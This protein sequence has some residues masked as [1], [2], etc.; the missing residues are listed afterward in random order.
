[1]TSFGARLNWNFDEGVY[2]RA[3]VLDG[4]PGDPSHP[5]RTTIDFDANDGVL[6]LA[7]VGLTNDKGRLW[8]LGGWMYTADFPDLV[9]AATHD[10]NLGAYVALEERLL[11]RDEG[12]AFDLAGSL[13]FG[14]ANDDI[15]PVSS[16][17]GATLVATGLIPTRGDDQL[18]FGIAVANTG[19]KA[20]SLIAGA[21]GDP[22]DREIDLELTYYADLTDWLA[23]QPDLQWV[24]APGSD[25]AVDDAFVAGLRVKLNRTWNYD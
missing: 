18:G 7:E 11:S 23:I 14:V 6:V 22:A 25:K 17:L 4:V 3:A 15:N 13:R 24:I 10:D 20:R 9:T 1:M 12:S 16:Y 21:G 2:A 5:K 8:S 19:D